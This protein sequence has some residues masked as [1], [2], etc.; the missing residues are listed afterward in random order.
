MTPQG[1]ADFLINHP[2]QLNSNHIHACS[3]EQI[4]D[5]FRE[6]AA[7]LVRI[8]ELIDEEQKP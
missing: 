7:S 3:I 2:D 1:Y 8:I 6:G 4:I 5:K